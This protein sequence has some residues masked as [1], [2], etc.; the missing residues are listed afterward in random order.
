VP[1]IFF[2]PP[3][4]NQMYRIIFLR[5]SQD[6]IFVILSLPHGVDDSGIT[7]SVGE[8]LFFKSL[9]K[10]AR[11]VQWFKQAQRGASG[12]HAG[13]MAH[14]WAG[15]H[16]LGARVATEKKGSARSGAAMMV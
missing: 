14:F 1:E 15:W 8:W 11:N 6:D 5:E 9:A 16:S 10:R 4:I 2:T 13:E 12:G 7:S 3:V